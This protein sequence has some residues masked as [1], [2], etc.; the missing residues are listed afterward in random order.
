MFRRGDQTALDRIIVH[1]FQLLKHHPVAHDRLRMRSLL[2]DLMLAPG[3]VRMTN[4]ECENTPELGRR[5]VDGQMREG[6]ARAKGI[7]ESMTQAWSFK[8]LCW[9]QYSNACTRMSQRAAVVKIG[10]Q[11]R[12]VPVMK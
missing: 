9:R 8:A 7:R 4:F 2:P 5:R 6:S 11:T 10:S 12:V 3:E 1:V